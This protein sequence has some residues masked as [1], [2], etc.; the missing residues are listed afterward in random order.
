M[1]TQAAP[2]PPALRASL[3]WAAAVP[4]AAVPTTTVAT[5]AAERSLYGQGAQQHPCG[6][7]DSCRGV[8]ARQSP[9]CPAGA[10]ACAS[11]T[12]R[13]V[14]PV[15]TCT[16]VH[17]CR[18]PPTGPSCLCWM[19]VCVGVSIFQ[20]HRRPNRHDDMRIRLHPHTHT[21]TQTLTQ[22]CGREAASAP[23]ACPPPCPGMHS[24]ASRARGRRLRAS[25]RC[26]GS[27][28]RQRA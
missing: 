3:H 8:R 17:L 20:G 6:R 19:C 1:G 15:M 13:D 18:Q 24:R 28:D 2:Q 5:K 22:T 12:G 16:S 21:L 11:L 10:E 14:R 7:G 27:P 23:I 26:A 4:E 25:P 9:P